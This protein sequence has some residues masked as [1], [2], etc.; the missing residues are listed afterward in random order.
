MR[1]TKAHTVSIVLPLPPR[2]ASPNFRGHTIARAREIAVYRRACNALYRQARLARAP[3]VIRLHWDWYLP[4]PE[5]M[6][7][8]YRRANEYE[9]R[10]DDDAIG[11]M[12]A[13]RDALQDAGVVPDDSQR[14][15]RQGHVVFHS[16]GHKDG[17]RCVVLMIELVTD[18][19]PHRFGGGADRNET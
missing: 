12:K 19:E 15:V 17:G 9:P 16:R 6:A 11:A 13:A 2:A 5:T 1:D 10:D 18:P 7:E 14:Y 4:R 3:G 8:R